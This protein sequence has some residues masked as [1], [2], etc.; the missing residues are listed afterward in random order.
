MIFLSKVKRSN[1]M[2]TILQFNLWTRSS[3]VGCYLSSQEES[4]LNYQ[5]TTKAQF[6]TILSANDAFF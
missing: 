2:L 6:I 4:K 5:N 1:Q 3:K